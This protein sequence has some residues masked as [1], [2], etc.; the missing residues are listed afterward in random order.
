MLLRATEQWSVKVGMKSQRPH[1]WAGLKKIPQWLTG[2]LAIQMSKSVYL[3]LSTDVVNGIFSGSHFFCVVIELI[4]CVFSIVLGE[5]WMHVRKKDLNSKPFTV[6]SIKSSKHIWTQFQYL[7]SKN[8]ANLID[9][10][11]SQ[12]DLLYFEFLVV[13]ILNNISTVFGL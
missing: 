12:N 8:S 3:G 7:I 1:K 13:I 10:T 2:T 9:K 11:P 6:Y 4:I 5:R